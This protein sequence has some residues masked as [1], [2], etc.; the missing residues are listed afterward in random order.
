MDLPPGPLPAGLEV[1]FAENDCSAVDLTPRPLVAGYH[2]NQ[3]CN[4]SYKT[5]PFVLG[6]GQ[7]QGG[8]DAQRNA[9]HHNPLRCHRWRYGSLLWRD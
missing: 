5:W 7:R 1:L 2:S 8:K 9:S 6:Q 3:A 4:K